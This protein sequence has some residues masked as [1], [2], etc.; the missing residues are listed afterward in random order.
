MRQFVL[1]TTALT[2]TSLSVLATLTAQPTEEPTPK[3][4][5]I[6]KQEGEIQGM[7]VENQK[8]TMVV[9]SRNDSATKHV[10]EVVPYV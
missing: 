3:H 2:L 6:V 10:P 9:I 4:K 7:W 8:C 5:V 1:T